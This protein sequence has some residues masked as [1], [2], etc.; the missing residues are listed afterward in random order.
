VTGRLA[1][2]APD[3]ARQARGVIRSGQAWPSRGTRRSRSG[4]LSAAG[5]RRRHLGGRSAM[6]P[7]AGP[8]AAWAVEA[9][10][11]SIW[12][13]SPSVTSTRMSARP[14]HDLRK[15]R[16]VLRAQPRKSRQARQELRFPPHAAATDRQ[17]G[18]AAPGAA[19]PADEP[20]RARRTAPR[21]IQPVPIEQPG[22]ST[23]RVMDRRRCAGALD[24]A[25]GGQVR[26]AA[27]AAFHWL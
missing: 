11:A 27:A 15:R 7:G 5:C 13:S 22:R 23:D 16:G 8:D 21:T 3:R 14:R 19:G 1:A 26:L 24:E 6:T 2:R 25:A 18:V 9:A 12:Q 10:T 17:F 4:P 20:L